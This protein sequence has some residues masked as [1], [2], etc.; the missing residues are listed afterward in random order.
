METL[1]R[2]RRGRCPRRRCRR[3]QAAGPEQQR[4]H[5]DDRN[6]L[7]RRPV[8][9]HACRLPGSRGH[10]RK[11]RR[12]LL[13]GPWA[14]DG[15]WATWRKTSGRE[16]RPAWRW[17]R[18]DARLRRLLGGRDRRSASAI[19]SA[20]PRYSALASASTVSRVGTFSPRSKTPRW[21]AL[22]P[23][24]AASSGWLKPR[25]MRAART[26]APKRAESV[27]RPM[28]TDSRRATSV[29]CDHL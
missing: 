8:P 24:D 2:A 5:G 15:S 11:P 4:M 7:R 29:R 13:D 26:R 14:T 12:R 28:P 19:N 25:A 16:D 21:F 9:G 23:T 10:R 18:H 17:G 20:T 6:D 3:L 1:D 22:K 27:V